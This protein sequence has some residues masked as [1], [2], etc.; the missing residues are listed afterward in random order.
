[1]LRV[2]PKC[3]PQRHSTSVSEVVSL[4]I[5]PASQDHLASQRNDLSRLRSGMLINV[6]HEMDLCELIPKDISATGL[7]LFRIETH[8]I[9][10]NKEE[11]KQ[12][13]NRRLFV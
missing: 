11:P 8:I 10:T 7:R 1:M 3:H 13:H 12:Q 5:R 2:I 4:W 6:E 9:N